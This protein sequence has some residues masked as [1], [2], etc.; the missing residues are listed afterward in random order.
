MEEG[1]DP[2]PHSATR[3]R[4]V[5]LKDLHA[6]NWTLVQ[7]T[8]RGDRCVDIVVGQELGFDYSESRANALPS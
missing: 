2:P 8:D 6:R 1:G 5:L 4:G 7:S 3:S